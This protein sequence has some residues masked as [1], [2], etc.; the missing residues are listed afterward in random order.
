MRSLFVY[1]PAR[2]SEMRLQKVCV[3]SGRFIASLPKS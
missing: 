3:R 2:L 1:T